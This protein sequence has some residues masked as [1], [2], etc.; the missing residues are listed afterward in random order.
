MISFHFYLIVFGFR[1]KE[2]KNIWKN[3]QNVILSVSNSEIKTN[4]WNFNYQMRWKPG[5][6]VLFYL[7]VAIYLFLFCVRSSWCSYV[8]IMDLDTISQTILFHLIE[9]AFVQFELNFDFMLTL[10][11]FLTREFKIS[12]FPLFE[13]LPFPFHFDCVVN[14]IESLRSNFI[15]SLSLHFISFLFLQSCRVP[16]DITECDALYE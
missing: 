4:L 3:I 5:M 6:I 7:F 13:Y 9:S 14:I 10:A 16:N 15:S 8:T 12:S 11:F 1:R 2:R